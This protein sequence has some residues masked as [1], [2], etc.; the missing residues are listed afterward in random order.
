MI[1]LQI[2]FYMIRFECGVNKIFLFFTQ[3]SDIKFNNIIEKI[4]TFLCSLKKIK[5]RK[6][7]YKRCLKIST[8]VKYDGQKRYFLKI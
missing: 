5:K 6:T 8:C 2:N 3:A 7:L 1:I 4:D